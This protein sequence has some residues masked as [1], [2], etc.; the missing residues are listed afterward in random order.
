MILFIILVLI[1]IVV[2]KN[3]RVVQQS[4]C[5]VI[6]SLGTYKTTWESC[7]HIKIPFIENIVRKI[8][9]KEQVSDFEPQPVITKDNVTMQIDSVVYWRIFDPKLFTYGVENPI[10]ALENLTATTLRNIIGELDLDSTLTS[11]DTINNKMRQILDKAT[12]AWGI[13]VTRVELKNIM[14]PIEIRQAME[15][16]MKAER[17]KRKSILEAEGHQQSIVL[18][19]KGDKEAAIL[20][21]EAEKESAIIRAEGEA[22]SIKLVYEAE[23]NGLKMLS[24]T[25]VSK[26]V[27]SLKKLEA[28]KEVGNGR[29]TKIIV[30]TELASSASQLQYIS[31]MIGMPKTEDVDKSEMVDIS[32]DISD[33][34]CKDNKDN[35]IFDNEDHCCEDN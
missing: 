22:N 29:A 9:L 24:E 28:L 23:A 15:Q 8:S 10:V 35:K 18:R 2:I 13:K 25:N 4:N 26:N 19:A 11:R 6:E 1:V 30:P 32:K 20:Q 5:Y 31:E 16:Q 27:L 21:A 12:D 17:E 33:P 7:L 3:V 14:P 34:C